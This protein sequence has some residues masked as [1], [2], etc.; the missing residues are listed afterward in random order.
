MIPDSDFDALTKAHERALALIRG[1][2]SQRRDFIELIDFERKRYKA[3]ITR[4]EALLRERKTFPILLPVVRDFIRLES[5]GKVIR[6]IAPPGQT[7]ACA[8]CGAMLDKGACPGTCDH[9]GKHDACDCG[10]P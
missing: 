2:E 6:A 10:E 3:R 8:T 5:D 4:L 7:W 9:C 1:H